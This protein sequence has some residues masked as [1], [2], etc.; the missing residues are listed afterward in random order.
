[1]KKLFIIL[2]IFVAFELTLKAQEVSYDTLV[3]NV[4]VTDSGIYHILK[5]RYVYFYDTLVLQ[6]L[7][8]NAI[9]D[10]IYLKND[11]VTY[12]TSYQTRMKAI[13]KRLKR[14]RKLL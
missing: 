6:N 8:N 4:I 11:G 10:S 1:M 13:K 2:L 9:S 5:I 7:Y 3:N 14:L 12:Q